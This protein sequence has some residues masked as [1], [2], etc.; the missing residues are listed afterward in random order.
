MGPAGLG[1]RKPLALDYLIDYGYG[2]EVL[3]CYLHV[4][5]ASVL[6]YPDLVSSWRVVPERTPQCKR[7][8]D[9]PRVTASAVHTPKVSHHDDAGGAGGENPRR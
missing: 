4:N 3:A 5:V 7:Q 1:E 8:Q 2:V 9:T 6:R